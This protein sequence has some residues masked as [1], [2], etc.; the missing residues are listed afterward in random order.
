MSTIIP[1]RRVLRPSRSV[2][3]RR[4]SAFRCQVRLPH[5]TPPCRA[6]LPGRDTLVGPGRR[7]HLLGADARSRLYLR[8]WRRGGVRQGHPAVARGR[9]TDLTHARHLRD[10]PLTRQCG[11]CQLCCR[12]LPA[13]PL[14][15]R[16]AFG[17]DSE[18][19][20][21]RRAELALCGCYGSGN[22]RC[23]PSL[24][25]LC[26]AHWWALGLAAALVAEGATSDF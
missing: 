15:V 9:D 6:D 2:N 12:L 3:V 7:H 19:P 5:L 25:W 22:L 24:P 18:R 1:Y 17:D 10:K 21:S 11:D 4:Q 16:P 26:G 23:L 14:G 13:P 8:P 20:G